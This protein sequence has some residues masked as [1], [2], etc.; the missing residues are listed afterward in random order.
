[1]DSDSSDEGNEH[2][3]IAK[4]DFNKLH[5]IQDQMNLSNAQQSE[6]DITKLPKLTGQGQLNKD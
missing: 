1:M 6:Y 4:I 3:S 5:L 2:N